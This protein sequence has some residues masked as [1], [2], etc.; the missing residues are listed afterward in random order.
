[1]FLLNLSLYTVLLHIH[2]SLKEGKSVSD[3]ITNVGNLLSLLKGLHM[4]I[5]IDY[6]E[7]KNLSN[8][9]CCFRV[10]IWGV[11]TA[12][13]S[14]NNFFLFSFFLVLFCLF[15]CLFCEW[16]IVYG[17]FAWKLQ[18]VVLGQITVFINFDGS[19]IELS[20]RLYPYQIVDFLPFKVFLLCICKKC[21]W[22]KI[23]QTETHFA[24]KF[25]CELFMKQNCA[26]SEK[27]Y[28]FKCRLFKFN[29]FMKNC[30]YDIMNLLISVYLSIYEHV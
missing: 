24:L 13:L 25:K 8:D 7:K 15:F 29:A 28:Y 18:F 22:I 21:V 11:Y 23:H 5:Y 9:Q 12:C 30:W 20:S 26:E 6:I 3:C 17:A 16:N 19:M 27:Q 14:C 4:C 1:M 10:D 2:I